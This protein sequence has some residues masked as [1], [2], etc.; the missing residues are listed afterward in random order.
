M[1][2][3]IETK[4]LKLRPVTLADAGDMYEYASDDENTYYVFNTHGSIDDTRYSIA[5]FFIANP[6]GKFGIELKD[7]NK[8]IGTVDLRVNMKRSCAEI[9]YVLNKKYFNNGYTTEA[10]QELIKFAFET[11]ELEKVFA[12]CNKENKASEAVM[13]KIGMSKEA[14]LR[15]YERWKDGEW[16]DLLQY[17]ILSD[18]HFKKNT[19]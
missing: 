19:S 9:G 7:E 2:A 17:G 3:I 6:L 11:L 14:E 15:H 10:A 4:R 5:N 13:K 16:I 12:T 18:E 1:N 8:L